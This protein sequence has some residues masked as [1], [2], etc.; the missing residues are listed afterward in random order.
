MSGA[1][2]PLSLCLQ[3]YYSAKFASNFVANL[4]TRASHTEKKVLGVEI[5]ACTWVQ[6]N[7]QMRREKHVAQLRG[8]QPPLD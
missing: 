6:E 2:T 3:F 7:N 5:S 1:M 4:L 8:L